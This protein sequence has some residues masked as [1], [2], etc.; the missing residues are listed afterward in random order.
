MLGRLLSTLLAVVLLGGTAVAAPLDLVPTPKAVT[1]GEGRFEVPAGAPTFAGATGPRA[2]YALEVLKGMRVSLRAATNARDVAAAAEALKLAAPPADRWE[3]A[4][5]L[6]CSM[7]GNGIRL[8][9]GPVGLIYGV[10][11]LAQ[12]AAQGDLRRA[13]APGDQRLAH[14]S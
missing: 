3:E 7:S 10:H 6:D 1:V 4:F 9:G 14:R 13:A 2:A 11:T 12:L 5:V 8:T